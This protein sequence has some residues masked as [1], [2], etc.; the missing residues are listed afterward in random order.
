LA[1][2]RPRAKFKEEKDG[3]TQKLRDTIRRLQSDNRKLKQEIATYEAAFQKNIQFL[4]GKTKD[5]SVEDLIEGA[6]KEQTLKQIEDTK[7]LTFKEM[8][9]KW[10]CNSCD[11]GVLKL[12]IVTRPD[13][14]FYMR[15]CGNCPK[16]TD[17]KP[18]HDKVEGV[19]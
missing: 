15:K 19:K 17:L 5:L 6:K 11:V 10:K 13:G 12:I 9:A 4:K 8:E 14:R 1:K 3:E 2:G 7:E 18:Y 16:R